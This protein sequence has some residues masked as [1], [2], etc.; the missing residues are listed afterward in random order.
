MSLSTDFSSTST[1]TSSHHS[2]D[3]AFSDYMDRIIGAK[4]IHH[5]A[6]MASYNLRAI[7]YDA[8][9]LNRYDFV[10]Y[11]RFAKDEERIAK[12]YQDNRS[13]EN[14]YEDPMPTED[15]EIRKQAVGSLCPRLRVT[16]L[17][18]ATGA[19]RAARGHRSSRR[20][21]QA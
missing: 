9:L 8:D 18:L 13:G 21:L 20:G 3:H 1:P 2:A 14:P 10:E 12:W 4:R 6:T 15:A 5:A 17:I 19:C 11:R 7:G 16:A